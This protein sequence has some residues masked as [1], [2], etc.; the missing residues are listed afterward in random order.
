MTGAGRSELLP[1]TSLKGVGPS[2]AERLRRLGIESVQDLLF[3]LPLRYEDRTKVVPIGA[4]RPG[5]RGVLWARWNS[6]RS[7]SDAGVRCSCG[8]ATARAS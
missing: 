4:L 8:S 7:C 6:P 2:L 1:V 5:E 3:L